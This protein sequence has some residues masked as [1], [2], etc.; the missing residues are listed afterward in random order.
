MID[1]IEE[2]RRKK[3]RSRN[4]IEVFALYFLECEEKSWDSGTIFYLRIA[5]GFEL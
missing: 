5:K 1:G 2:R 4:K 3:E